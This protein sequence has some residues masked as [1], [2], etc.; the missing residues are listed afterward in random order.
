MKHFFSLAPKVLIPVLL[1]TTVSTAYAAKFEFGV[2]GD[3]PY[4][5]ARAVELEAL[6]TEVGK[7]KRVRFLVHAGDFKSG[8]SDCSDMLFADRR[9]LFDT[10]K[11][12]FVYI[13]GDNE[14]TDCWR[15][16]NG[17][18]NPIER[19]DK[20]R[21]VFFDTNQ[22][23]GARTIT[24]TRQSDVA[25]NPD[26]LP[27]RENVIWT[28]R[29][30]VFVGLNVQ[31]SNNGQNQS[32]TTLPPDPESEGDCPPLD[33]EFPIRNAANL[34]WLNRAFDL[35][36]Y[37]HAPALAVFIQGNPLK[38]YLPTPGQIPR[39]SSTF[40]ISVP[41]AGFSSGYFD[42]L[43]AFRDRAV[44]FGK[45]VLLVHGDTHT[46]RIDKPYTGQVGQLFGETIADG[47]MGDG[48]YPIPNVTRME[49]YGNPVTRWTRVK[50]DTKSPVVFSF[51]D[52]G[53]KPKRE[54]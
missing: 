25:T 51:E 37:T 17:S 48:L 3:V 41:L 49:T 21:E 32:C 24:L 13:T 19:L 53:P 2:I 40:P 28:K 34:S 22:S 47:G 54:D 30:V 42:F 35:A 20:L 11:T 36:E 26:F 23:L 29:R 27:Y 14:W 6:L 9:A 12:P 38:Y 44:E 8:S 10:S 5:D 43:I 46:H 7:N 45:P 39:L 52:G 15:A 31:G 18:Y 33:V 16:N 50:V 1:A 4:N